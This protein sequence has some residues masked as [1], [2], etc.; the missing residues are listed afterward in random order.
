ML[1]L[2]FLGCSAVIAILA[3]LISQWSPPSAP[4]ITT[5]HQGRNNSVLFLGN[6]EFGLSNV[7]VATAA[8]LLEYHPD[9]EVHF[10]SFPSMGGRLERI[11]NVVGQKKKKKTESSSSRSSSIVFHELSDLSFLAVSMQ[12]GVTLTTVTHPPGIAS[13][14]MISR[15]VSY[16]V[17]PWSGE[18]HITLFEEITGRCQEHNFSPPF[19][20]SFFLSYVHAFESQAVRFPILS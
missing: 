17:S 1:K 12:S 19:F 15:R 7:L 6:S 13:A 16:L 18:D 5:Y 4:R 9:V 3:A 14:G 2:L 11:S 20:L 10:A 8:T